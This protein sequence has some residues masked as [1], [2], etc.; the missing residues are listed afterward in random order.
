MITNSK[1]FVDE[2]VGSR[3]LYPTDYK[4]KDIV[5]QVNI[6]R[7][8]LPNIPE[9]GKEQLKLA[10][11]PLPPHAEGWFATLN[12]EKL[13]PTYG[14]AVEKVFSVFPR[15]R[16]ICNVRNHKFGVQYLRRCPKSAKMLQ[17]LAQE[18][19]PPFGGSIIVVAAQ[20]GMGHKD[21]NVRQA[22]EL[23]V[24]REFGLGALD[25]ACMLLTHPER[26]IVWE[27]SNIDCAGDEFS[28]RADQDFSSVP[29]FYFSQGT[30]RF[31]THQF[32]KAMSNCAPASGFLSWY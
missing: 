31:S 2:E 22:H 8:A 30:I 1:L 13:A 26:G 18:Q 19:K 20:F 6:L 25:V 32:D 24:E 11:Q 10:K 14:Q 4:V 29:Y 21:H 7:K 28:L 17:R 27:D 12:W 15:D 23:F 9:L 3:Y 16:G 5:E